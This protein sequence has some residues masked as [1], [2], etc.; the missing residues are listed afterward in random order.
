[1]RG[2]K[3]V[4]P[5]RDT[6]PIDILEAYG[7]YKFPLGEGLTLKAGKFASLLGYEVIEAPNNLNFSRS[8]MFSFAVPLTH[9]GA[10]LSYQFGN[11]SRVAAGRGA[12]WDVAR[13]NTSGMSV[14]GQF[15]FPPA[16]AWTAG[17]NWITGPEQT[18]N[19]HNLRTVLDWTLTYSGIDKL[20]LGA[21]V[22]Y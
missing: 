19:S 18:G 14:M 7:S 4:F 10:L 17:M 12:G 2:D 1:F 20:T 6:V 15:G 9:V 11:V 16:K 5:Y 3:D 13:D 8:F 22:D 21:N